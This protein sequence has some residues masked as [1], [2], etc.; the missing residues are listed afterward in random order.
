MAPVAATLEVHTESHKHARP[1]STYIEHYLW[2]N[3]D[4]PVAQRESVIIQRF[5]L[6][7]FY[8]RILRHLVY[9]R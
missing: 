9:L 1:Q 3:R 4:T 2:Q 7:N 5:A 8:G 6:L